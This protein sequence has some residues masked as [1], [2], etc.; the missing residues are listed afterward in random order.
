MV[1]MYVFSECYSLLNFVVTMLEFI[2]GMVTCFVAQIMFICELVNFTCQ[3][4]N[5]GGADQVLVPGFAD[6]SH[7][8]RIAPGGC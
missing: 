8:C 4:S 1:A 7:E 6:V 2:A 3:V 5:S